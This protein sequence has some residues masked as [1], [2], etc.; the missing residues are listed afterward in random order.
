MEKLIIEN[1]TDKPM[2]KILPYV[3]T[4]V[5]AGKIS[6]NMNEQYCYHTKFDS[7]IEVLAYRNKCS[8]RLVVWG[9]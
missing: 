9:I 1:R 6:G 7:G 8:D 3:E 4:V 5:S 2:E